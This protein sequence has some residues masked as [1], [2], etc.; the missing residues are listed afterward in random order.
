MAFREIWEMD[1]PRQLHHGNFWGIHVHVQVGSHQFIVN[2]QWGCF[3][4][5]GKRAVGSKQIHPRDVPFWRTLPTFNKVPDELLVQGC[6]AFRDGLC[7]CDG[8]VSTLR[9]KEKVLQMKNREQ[10][11]T[12]THK[13]LILESTHHNTEVALWTNFLPLKYPDAPCREY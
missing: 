11:N 9:G 2:T 10:I 5:R 13:L 6:L 1:S 8:K 7:M 12:H 3:F 4:A